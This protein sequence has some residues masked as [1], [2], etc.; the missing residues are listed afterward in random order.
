M[1]P[2]PWR[3]GEENTVQ[4]LCN[5]I[6]KLERRLAALEKRLEKRAVPEAWRKPGLDSP[7]DTG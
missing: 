6:A 2:N 7:A 1:E 5:R 3:R 4:Q